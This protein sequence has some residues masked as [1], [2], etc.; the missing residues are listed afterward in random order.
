[1]FP[2]VITVAFL[3]LLDCQQEGQLTCKKVL[4]I[5][6]RSGKHELAFKAVVCLYNVVLLGRQRL[7]QHHITMLLQ[8][9]QDLEP[10]NLRYQQGQGRCVLERLERLRV[11][12]QCLVEPGFLCAVRVEPL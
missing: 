3:S 9:H 5:Y 11:Y 7:S 8:L 4:S 12:R 1:M 10:G 2:R 6:V